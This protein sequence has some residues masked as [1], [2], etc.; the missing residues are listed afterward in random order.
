MSAILK[1]LQNRKM[2]VDLKSEVVEFGGAE[3]ILKDSGEA[4]SASNNAIGGISSELSKLMSKV[5]SELKRSVKAKDN[6]ED[7]MQDFTRKAKDLGFNPKDSKGYSDA[8]KNLE[9]IYEAIQFLN[10]VKKSIG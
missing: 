10:S 6:L 5:N 7:S 4:L 3:D 2:E 9:D 1:A 8:K